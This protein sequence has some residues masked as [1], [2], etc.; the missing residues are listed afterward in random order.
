MSRDYNGKASRLSFRS[1]PQS[2]S[3]APEKKS[4]SHAVGNV[5]S[6]YLE[7]LAPTLH[8]APVQSVSQRQSQMKGKLGV[9]SYLL[10]TSPTQPPLE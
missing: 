8:P 2:A 7:L 4:P 1:V 10:S 6:V 3:L 5:K 9:R